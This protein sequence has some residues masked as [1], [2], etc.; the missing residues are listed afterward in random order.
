MPTSADVVID[1]GFELGE[2]PLYDAASSTLYGVDVPR[3]VVW[4]WSPATG[5]VEQLPV[6]EPVA[7]PS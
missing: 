3:G 1:A 5:G 2:G 4:G 7:V 6:G